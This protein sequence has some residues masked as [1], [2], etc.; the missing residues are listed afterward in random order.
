MYENVHYQNIRYCYSQ[1]YVI[2][3]QYVTCGGYNGVRAVGNNIYT[4]DAPARFAYLGRR[5]EG[6]AQASDGHPP[7][8]GLSQT[9]VRFGVGTRGRRVGGATSI[10]VTVAVAVV[11]VVTAAAAAPVLLQVRHGRGLLELL[12]LHDGPVRVRR[13]RRGPGHHGGRNEPVQSGQPVTHRARN[14]QQ[15]WVTRTEQ[16]GRDGGGN[17]DPCVPR[18]AVSPPGAQ[19]DHA[20]IP[21]Y[22]K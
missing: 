10:T 9:P 18:A 2:S 6:A 19:C 13:R 15:Q 17:G 8:A 11:V 14:R 1:H 7:T 16:L 5:E 3:R 21:R 22:T 4:R 12:L 20:P